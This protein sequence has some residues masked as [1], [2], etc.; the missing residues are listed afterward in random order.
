MDGPDWDACSSAPWQR[1]SCGTR[2]F[3]CSSSARPRLNWR[4]APPRRDRAAVAVEQVER[5]VERRCGNRGGIGLAQPV[6]PGP[7]LLVVD[8]HLGV[9]HQRARGQ[10]RD[11]GR[12]V[13]EAARVIH[14]V[15]AHEADALAVL[16]DGHPPA[17]DPFLVDP[18]GAVE[19][20]A[21]P[22]R[23]HRNEFRDHW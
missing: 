15:A 5:H 21:D 2:L 19:R 20:L 7:E 14:A 22:P 16:V 8:G 4:G 12:H 10:L 1:Q 9:Q 11:G 3:R 23:S 13:A 18:A 6:E 17:V